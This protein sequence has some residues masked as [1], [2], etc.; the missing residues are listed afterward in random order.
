MGKVLIGYATRSGAAADI[1]E[2]V[3]DEFRG[4]GHQ[5]RVANLEDQPRVDDASLV[6]LGSGINSASWYPEALAWVKES[7]AELH[8]TKVAVFNTCLN[9]ADPAK[10]EVALGYNDAVAGRCG[11]LA[12]ET[13]AGR[14]EPAKVGFLSKLLARFTGR[15]AQDHVDGRQAKAWADEL[16]TFLAA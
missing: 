5:V 10:R 4:A 12:S 9:A 2:A 6:V 15:K 1:A 16:L 8:D 11:S 7:S 13:F 3:A 14:F